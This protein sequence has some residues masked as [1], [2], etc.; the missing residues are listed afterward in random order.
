MS[1]VNFAQGEQLK[2]DLRK[3][4]K[5][6]SDHNIVENPE[7]LMIDEMVE[8]EV[9]I[10]GYNEFYESG[11]STSGERIAMPVSSSIARM[12]KR[13]ALEYAL[14]GAKGGANGQNVYLWFNNPNNINKQ[15]VE[16]YQ[17]KGYYSYIK[18]GTR[19]AL[20]GGTEDG[21]VQNLRLWRYNKNNFNQHWKKVNVE[22]RYFR[23][24]KRNS[25]SVSIDDNNGG[26]NKQNAHLRSSDSSDQNQHWQFI[27]V[28]SNKD[29]VTK[30]DSEN[31]EFKPSEISILPNPTRDVFSLNINRFTKGKVTATIYTILGNKKKQI[32]LKPG[33][34]R[35]STRNLSLGK[36]IYLIRIKS[37]R[38]GSATKKI[39]VN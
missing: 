23:L 17:G 20:D 13:N 6:E 8:N 34:N 7:G 36:G 22:R 11:L 35:I 27:P 30:S 26:E 19:F 3:E 10:L 4:I 24:E 1:D 38:G 18:K 15:W 31:L 12:V 2:K 29:E 33:T 14:D 32:H 16:V 39:I 9:K 28:N 25:T 5:I 21:N 37:S